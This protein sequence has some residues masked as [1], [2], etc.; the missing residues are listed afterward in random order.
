M[1]KQLYTHGYRAQR[2]ERYFRHKG[3]QLFNIL[4]PWM[5]PARRRERECRMINEAMFDKMASRDPKMI[6]EAIDEVNDFTRK[7][8]REDGY[9]KQILPQVPISN[10]ELDRAGWTAKPALEGEEDLGC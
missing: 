8:M 1:R 10:E 7:R 4:T 3:R 5:W 9:L 2:V 6:K